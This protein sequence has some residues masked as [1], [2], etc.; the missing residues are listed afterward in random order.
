[1][2]Q[3]AALSMLILMTA[4]GPSLAVEPV[5]RWGPEYNRATR[6]PRASDPLVQRPPVRVYRKIR[7]PPKVEIDPLPRYGKPKPAIERIPKT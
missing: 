1:M 7:P 5:N 4:G 2:K 3:A 6:V